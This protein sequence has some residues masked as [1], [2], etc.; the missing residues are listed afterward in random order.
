[1]LDGELEAEYLGYE[2]DADATG[3]FVV[4]DQRLR[5]QASRVA[6]V[7]HAEVL[8]RQAVL[9]NASEPFV[10][11]SNELLVADHEDHVAAGVGVRAELAAG[12]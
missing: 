8:S 9:A 5:E 11:V 4:Q 1:M 7:L 3:G 2:N 6:C 10:E 12:A